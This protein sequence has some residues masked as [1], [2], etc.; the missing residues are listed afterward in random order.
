MRTRMILIGLISVVILALLAFV[1]SSRLIKPKQDSSQ[2]YWP[3][4]SWFS[5]MPEEGGLNSVKLAE[6]LQ[7]IQK[8]N[9]QIDSLLVIRNGAVLLDATFYPYDSKYLHDLASVTKSFMTTL[10]GIAADQGKLNLDQ[11]VLSFFPERTIANRD[12]R[13]ERLTVRH[14]A[15]M[16]NGFESG[17]V[18]GDN[19]TI[20][21]MRANPDWVQA[22]LDRKMVSEPGTQNTY[23]SPGMHLLSAILQKATGMTALEFARKNLFE[24]LGIREVYW[25]SDPQGYTHGWGDLHLK[26]GDAAKLGY[27]WLSNGVWEGKQIVS[28]D[29]VKDSVKYHSDFGG[30]DGYGY[31]WWLWEGGYSA[32]GRGGQA[33]KVTPVLNA[34]VVT[35]GGGF[36]YD[37][38]VNQHLIAAVVDT[39]K[40]LPANPAG[41]ARLAAMLTELA[42]PVAPQ[43]VGALPDTAKAISGKTY[44]FG[45]NTGDVET[46]GL[47]FNDSAEAILHIKYTGNAILTSRVGLDGIYRPTSEG[48]LRRGYWADSQTFILEIFDIGEHTFRIHFEDDH[49]MIESPELGIS[50]EGQLK[51]P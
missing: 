31:G 13:K 42:Q 4:Q 22:A 46:L 41:V 5:S 36:D 34:I 21:A 11:P 6:G 15:E 37:S 24:P 8:Q 23:D 45:P 40:P 25:K 14:L 32:E 2:V 30:G 17:C 12:A 38:E 1:I 3:T 20:E 19:P 29:W 39:N 28:A 48:E 9:S 35:T 33:V 47:E 26:P 16:M 50:F 18:K 49:V 43:P 27:L 51:K 7:A 44:V 10:I